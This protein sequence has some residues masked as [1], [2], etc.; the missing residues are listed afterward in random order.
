MKRT[1]KFLLLLTFV[2][3]AFALSNNTVLAQDAPIILVR[4]GTQFPARCKAGSGALFLKQGAGA[5]LYY[6]SADN[7]WTASGGTGGGGG[8][9]VTSTFGR[10]GAI[11]AANGDYTWAQINKTTSSLAD[12]ATRSASDLTSGTLPDAR[13]PATL[14]AASGVNLTSLPA[15]NLTGTLAGGIFP[16]TLPAVSGVNLTNL[17]AANLTGVLPALNG[18]ALVSLNAAN[19][20]SGTLPAAR[21]PATYPAGDG[22]AITNVATGAVSANAG[23]KSTCPKGN[24]YYNSTP[25][26]SPLYF[27]FDGSNSSGEVLV[28]GVSTVNQAN[29]NQPTFDTLTDGA[30][31]TWTFTGAKFQNAA[32]TI[33]GNNTLAIS[34]ATEGATGTILLT[35]GTGGNFVPVLPSGSLVIGATSAGSGLTGLLSTAA[36]AVDVLTFVKRGTTYIWSVGKGAR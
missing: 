16:A 15:A 12:L 10:T 26:A 8:G 35:Q 19:L 28:A 18:I 4:T 22:T 21:F 14:P 24:F 5:G 6:C 36:G 11:T 29:V 30:T 31:T 33:G 9:A 20:G 13:F 2:L 23:V 17:S 32:W 25:A 1:I 3:S 27:C 34:G 7:V